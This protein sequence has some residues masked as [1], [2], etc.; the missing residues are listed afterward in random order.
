MKRGS[1]FKYIQYDSHGESTA[2][3]PRQTLWN[4]NN[5]VSRHNDL[6]LN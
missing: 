3:I 6:R 4:R 1:Y 2:K 5:K